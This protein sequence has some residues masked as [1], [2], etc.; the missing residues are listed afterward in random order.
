MKL[1]FSIFFSACLASEAAV[2]L[3][4]RSGLIT[5]VLTNGVATS[6]QAA[7]P[8]F[9]PDGGYHVGESITVTAASPDGATVYWTTN[10]TTPT[11]NS[12]SIASGGTVTAP[13]GSIKAIAWKN[14]G[15]TLV[16]EVSTSQVYS[17]PPSPGGS[18]TLKDSISDT[19]TTYQAD[20]LNW[21]YL[22]FRWTASNSYTMRTNAIAVM[23]MGSPV[24][25]YQVQV[26]SDSTGSI[27]S[28][29]ATSE[30]R[31]GSTCPTSDGLWRFGGLSCSIT[32]GTTY[33]TVLR[34][35]NGTGYELSANKVSV[36]LKLNSGYP[37]WRKS[38]DPAVS[39]TDDV[40]NLMLR[41]ETWGD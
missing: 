9:S 41:F 29:L 14:N 23:T 3:D 13:V 35:I 20:V 4:I 34:M 22:A 32:S 12:S 31:N 11:T 15:L 19:G 8:T 28:L 5:R 26:Y 39:W 38:D 16:S 2:T 6:E 25:D 37:A 33:W 21:Y 17:V 7:P 30:T 27:G 40:S 36:L 10:G 18:Y 24:K 1:I